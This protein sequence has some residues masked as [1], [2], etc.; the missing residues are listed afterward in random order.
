ME[1]HLMQKTLFLFLPG[2]CILCLHF[3]SLSSLT[4][5]AILLTLPPTNVTLWFSLM[6]WF[7]SDSSIICP[8]FWLQCRW[9][10]CFNA[11]FTKV[12]MFM[13]VLD[14][15]KVLI[16]IWI[17]HFYLRFPDNSL[18]RYMFYIS[19]IPLAEMSIVLS[20]YVYMSSHVPDQNKWGSTFR[21]IVLQK[22]VSD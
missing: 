4:L 9:F 2:C 15:L 21:I 5:M 1:T 3:L 7:Q 8:M 13:C 12:F 10:A 14:I 11:A 19:V 17:L 22:Y 6:Q 16:S 18:C 20:A